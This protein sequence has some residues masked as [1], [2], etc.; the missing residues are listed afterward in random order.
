[1]TISFLENIICCNTIN[2][3]AAIGSSFF[4]TNLNR[5]MLWKWTLITFWGIRAGGACQSSKTKNTPRSQLFNWRIQ[6][7]ICFIF[8]HNKS[9][10]SCGRGRWK[11]FLLIPSEEW[12]NN[13]DQDQDY[14]Q[15]QESGSGSEEWQIE[16]GCDS[17]YQDQ[18]RYQNNCG[19]DSSTKIRIGIKILGMTK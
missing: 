3:S 19:D 14:D 8:S 1:M 10:S 4:V 2:S 5:R 12:Q 17:S 7:F 18:D 11:T 15:E 9:G 13:C 16:C 6:H